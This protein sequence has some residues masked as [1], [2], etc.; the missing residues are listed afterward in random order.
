MRKTPSKDVSAQNGHQRATTAQTDEQKAFEMEVQELI[1]QAKQ[2][3]KASSP[4]RDE[5]NA[6]S[7]EVAPTPTPVLETSAPE[8]QPAVSIP[9]EVTP[10]AAESPVSKGTVA[11]SPTE[12]AQRAEQLQ[13][14]LQEARRTITELQAEL[15]GKEEA[16]HEKPQERQPIYG[17]AAALPS[18]ETIT[19]DD[20]KLEFLNFT[21][22]HI[23]QFNTRIKKTEDIVASLAQNQPRAAA[24]QPA[25]PG[26]M[27][28]MNTLLLGICTLLLLG[29]F[30]NNPKEANSEEK[31]VAA[32]TPAASAP[33]TKTETPAE[34]PPASPASKETTP[35]PASA[36]PSNTVSAPAQVAA[37]APS[38]AH[39]ATTVAT[40][41]GKPA[42][43]PAAKTVA[44]PLA[45]PAAATPAPQA[46]PIATAAAPQA[47]PAPIPAPQPKQQVASA[48]KPVLK[49]APTP[50]PSRSQTA[51][52]SNATIQRNLSLQEALRPV[53]DEELSRERTARRATEPKTALRKPVKSNEAVSFGDD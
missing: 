25:K 26:W 30:F 53:T 16:L 27:Q 29:L 31:T 33:V 13:H 45:K 41:P 36:T 28:W 20:L 46:K 24:V 11:Q 38:P 23:D 14:D 35:T 40:P 5:E 37:A 47:K 17:H 10:L 7:A 9:A 51:A 1:R 12:D 43:V 34:T 39:T 3:L 50:A 6:A 21:S 15:A 52:K 42:P 18:T 48:P 22:A 19:R 4:F 2:Q 49:A 8:P 32:P 44:T